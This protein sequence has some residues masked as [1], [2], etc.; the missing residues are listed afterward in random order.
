MGDILVVI[1][2]MEVVWVED[3]DDAGAKYPTKYRTALTLVPQ[4]KIIW[5]K[6]SS[7]LRLRNPMLEHF[8]L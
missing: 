1:T 6:V 3:K 4:Q 2:G 8:C 7:V 5:P